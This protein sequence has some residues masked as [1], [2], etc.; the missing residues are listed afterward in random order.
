MIL[1][2]A[3][4]EP[5]P[6]YGDGQYVRDWLYVEDH[7]DALLLA[8]IQGR[9]GQSYCV[10]GHGE[11][12]NKQVVNQICTLLDEL[13]P[14]GAPHSR[15]ITPVTDRPGHDRRY[16][17]DPSLIC[18]ELGWQPRHEFETGLAATVRWYLEHQDWCINVKHREAKTEKEVA[19]RA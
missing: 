17:I 5:I 13:R 9:I 7:V 15:L 3:A 2:A 1:K 14:A 11:R 16:A 8:A 6:L 4:G 18:T 19:R 10:G 12:N